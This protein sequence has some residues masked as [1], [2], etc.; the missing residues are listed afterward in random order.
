MAYLLRVEHIGWS[1]ALPNHKGQVFL[2]GAALRDLIKCIRVEDV[3]QVLPLHYVD[4]HLRH[5]QP[6]V[7]GQTLHTGLLQMEMFWPHS[8]K[9]SFSHTQ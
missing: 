2:T 4:A 6:Q 1:L 5:C 9:R 8:Y 3:L 7:L